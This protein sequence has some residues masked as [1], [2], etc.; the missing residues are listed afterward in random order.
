MSLKRVAAGVVSKYSNKIE[1]F[2]AA[3]EELRCFV[4]THVSERDY[5][6]L[7]H[8]SRQRFVTDVMREIIKMH[9]DDNYNDDDDDQDAGMVYFR[10]CQDCETSS[11]SSSCKIITLKQYI[12]RSCGATVELNSPND[13]ND[14]EDEEY[15]DEGDENDEDDSENKSL[16]ISKWTLFK[17]AT[18]LFLWA[19][20]W[21]WGKCEK[22][23]YILWKKKQ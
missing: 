21:L 7:K 9:I 17:L 1:S 23:W 13:K 5:I 3:I 4:D 10:V 19:R 20:C 11:S 16:G 8:G 18:E 12:C 14:D 6:H 15:E 22:P 2:T